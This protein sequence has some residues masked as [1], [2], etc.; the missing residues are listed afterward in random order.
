M[1]TA[2]FRRIIGG[3]WYFYKL[4]IDTPAIRLFSKWM[5][6]P[7]RKIDMSVCVLLEKETYPPRRWTDYFMRHEV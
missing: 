5:L 4:G 6:T 7:P 2:L 1:E 3:T